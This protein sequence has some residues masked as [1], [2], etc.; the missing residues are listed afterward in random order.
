MSVY[1]GWAYDDLEESRADTVAAWEYV[2]RQVFRCRKCNK[3]WAK[4]GERRKPPSEGVKE[5]RTAPIT[6]ADLW[7]RLKLSEGEEFRQIRGR[8]FTNALSDRLCFQIALIGRSHVSILRKP[9]ITSHS[10]TR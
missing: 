9:S 7:T 1:E 5:P 3:E 4:S 2:E 8:G 6:V 10:R